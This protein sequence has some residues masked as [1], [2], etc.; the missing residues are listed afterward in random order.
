MTK[1][2]TKGKEK[3]EVKAKKPTGRPS[4]YKQEFDDIADAMTW[5]GASIPQIAEKLGVDESTVDKWM[6]DHPSFSAAIKEGREIADR[7]VVKSLYERATGYSTKATKMALTRHGEWRTME[8][9]EKF[10]PDPTSMIFWLKNRR[11]KEWREKLEV[12]G[13]VINVRV[14]G[15][16]EEEG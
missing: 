3:K 8:Y 2:T 16:D 11:P 5:L 10:P 12:E 1:K 7:R 9:I 13:L 6:K 14:Q 15:E 4:V